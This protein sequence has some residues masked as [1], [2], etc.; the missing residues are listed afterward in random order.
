MTVLF[1][2]STIVLFLAVDAI[3]HRGKVTTPLPAVTPPVR[4]PDGIFFAKS[5]TWLNLFPTGRAWLGVDDFVA[6]LLESPTVRFLVQPG[7]RVKRGQPI[8]ALQEDG[9]SLTVRSP[10]DGRVL[11]FNDELRQ[12]PDRLHHAPFSDGWVA[13][14]RPDRYSDVKDLML[15]EQVKPWMRAEFARLRDVFATSGGA[16]QPAMLQDGG[17]PVAGAMKQMG[18]EVWERFDREFLDVK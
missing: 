18:P 9:R 12:D 13:E 11:A 1:V 6:R 14:I 17:P 7:A 8:L 3:L 16:L 4:L 2:I 5:H 10:I 15:G